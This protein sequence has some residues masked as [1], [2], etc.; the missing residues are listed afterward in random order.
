MHRL[1]DKEDL[2]ERIRRE[3]AARGW[4]SARLIDEMQALGVSTPRSAITKI[5]KGQRE[6]SAHELWALGQVFGTTPDDL[7]KPIALVEQERAAELLERRHEGIAGLMGTIT[8]LVQVFAALDREFEQ[9]PEV[10]EWVF[11]RADAQDD[12]WVPAVHPADR[13]GVLEHPVVGPVIREALAALIV[14]A[15]G[16]VEEPEG[17]HGKH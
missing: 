12:R 13:F 15:S 11:N 14:H 6:V 7:L 5:E 4:S 3:R 9:N 8:E 2:A 16:I 1:G 10:W 17:N